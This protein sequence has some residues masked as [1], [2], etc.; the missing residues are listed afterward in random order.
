M[1][2]VYEVKYQEINRKNKMNILNKN[3]ERK[4]IFYTVYQ[5]EVKNTFIFLR[6]NS[7]LE[8]FFFN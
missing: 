2:A 6:L 1:I 4:R 7:G 8:I 3:F 5:Y